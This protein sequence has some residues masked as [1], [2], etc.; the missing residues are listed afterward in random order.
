VSLLRADNPTLDQLVM[1]HPAYL[2]HE[3]VMADG[4]YTLIRVHFTDT[5]P[6]YEGGE[7]LEVWDP[8]DEYEQDV[9]TISEFRDLVEEQERA[10]S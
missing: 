1:S 8:N 7:H 10:T 4:G 9:E 5:H 3:I 6:D 2:S